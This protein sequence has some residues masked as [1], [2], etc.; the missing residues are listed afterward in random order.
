MSKYM[1][2]IESKSAFKGFPLILSV[3]SGGEPTG[4]ITYER[5]AY[6]YA[7]DRVLWSLGKHKVVLRGG[8]NTKTGLQSILEMDTI[9]AIDNATSPFKFRKSAAPP[10]SNKTLFARDRS[11]CAYCGTKC[12]SK[13]LTRDH[14]V[15]QSKGGK[16][17]W[18]NVVAACKGC[19]NW[20]DNKTLEQADM[21]LLY[22][23]YIPSYHEHLILQ[24]RKILQDQMDFLIKGVSKN[25][26]LLVN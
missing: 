25:S 1:E 3:N 26:R 6:Y 14:I 15:P 5:C 17:T 8:T 20:K 22:I 2:K 23:P 19:N 7:K 12:Q 21:Q 24:N 16:D 13:D 10:L 11:I 4:W 9:V 18:E